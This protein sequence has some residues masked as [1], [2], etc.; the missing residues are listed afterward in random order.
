MSETRISRAAFLRAIPPGTKLTATHSALGPTNAHRTVEKHQSNA[1]VMKTPEGSLSYLH[2]QKGETYLQTEDG[3]KV[4][5]PEDKDA[6]IEAF[7]VEYKLGHL[8]EHTV[9][10]IK[11]WSPTAQTQG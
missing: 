6:K 5:V 11:V 3:F 7:F 8:G 4:C 1:V 2:F 10:K 9:K